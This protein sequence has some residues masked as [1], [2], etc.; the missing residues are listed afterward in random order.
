MHLLTPIWPI[1]T[2][3][4]LQNILI[5]NIYHCCKVGVSKIISALFFRD[6]YPFYP[7]LKGLNILETR[8]IGTLKT[9]FFLVAMHNLGLLFAIPWPTEDAKWSKF[10]I[11]KR[12]YWPQYGR[13][14]PTF[15]WKTFWFDNFYLWCKVAVSKKIMCIFSTFLQFL[16][17]NQWTKIPGDMGNWDLVDNVVSYYHAKTG[18]IINKS[19]TYR[20]SQKDGNCKFQMHLMTPK[21]PILTYFFL[22]TALSI[23]INLCYENTDSI[24]KNAKL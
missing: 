3:S 19:V 22:Q 10:S 17:K 8:V 21:W 16:S 5:D 24:C 6:F 9:M 4:F 12:T 2:Y 1:L 18:L 13:Y 23:T 7:K 14:W 20:G 11:F 15:S